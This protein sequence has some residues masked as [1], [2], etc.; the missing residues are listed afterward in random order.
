MFYRPEA[1]DHGLPHNPF[2]AIVAPRPIGWISTLDTDG[3]ANLAP[4]SFFN[5]LCDTPPMVM[6]ASGG[7]KADQP[8]GKD[9]V[10]NV[11]ATG[12]F[13]V[14]IVPFALQDQMNA[15][16]APL[17]AGRDEFDAAGLEKAASVAIAAPHVAAS[18]AVL[19]CRLF[20]IIELPGAANTMVIGEVVGVHIK[21]NFIVNGKFDITLFQP[22]ARLGY[23]DYAAISD[24]F[25]LKRP[26]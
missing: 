8:Q 23:M 25:S 26:T 15:S 2:K 1:N 24:V 11:R 10:S 12:E 13:A 22:M 16:S 19:E 7:N 6:F 14:N 9:S 20:K 18:P 5:A 17:P 4:Y 21:D 3:N